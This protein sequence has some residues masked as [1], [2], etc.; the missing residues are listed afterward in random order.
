MIRERETTNTRVAGRML[1]PIN[2]SGLILAVVI[3][4]AKADKFYSCSFLEIQNHFSVS[5]R[6]GRKRK[7]W[8]VSPGTLNKTSSESPRS[9][10]Q[11]RSAT[12]PAVL[13]ISAGLKIF[14]RSAGSQRCGVRFLGLTPHALRCR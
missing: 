8:G 10:R 13:Y 6:S 12:E 9:G 11:V 3:V 1:L 2:N 7:A 5:P 4:A 14:P